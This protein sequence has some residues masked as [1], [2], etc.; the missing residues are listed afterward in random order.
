MIKK[1]ERPGWAI[2]IVDVNSPKRCTLEMANNIETNLTYGEAS[3]WF[4][5]NI[6]PINKLLESAVEVYQW[7]DESSWISNFNFV[8]G[9]DVKQMCKKKALLINIEPIKKETTKPTFDEMKQILEERAGILPLLG[10]DQKFD[11]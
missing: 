4:N 6:E 1:I 5:K 7:P 11:E 8:S 10:G 9:E 2:P 3:D